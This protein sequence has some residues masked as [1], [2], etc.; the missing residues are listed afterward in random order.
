MKKIVITGPEST[1]KSILTKTIASHCKVAYVKEMARFYLE[2]LNRPYTRDD[3]S[4]I[5][6]MQLE[7]EQ[8]IQRSGGELLICDTDLR[9]IK[10]WSNY[11]YGSTDP[12]ILEEIEK[13]KV[14]L[15]LLSY[16]DIPWEEDPLRENPNDR[17]E[18][19]N[20]YLQELRQNEQIFEIVSGQFGKREKCAIDILTKYQLIWENS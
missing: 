2:M 6:K 16:P 18:L 1:G 12:Y 14:D 10:I 8:R 11:K 7:E 9:T 13:S 17:E 19:F 3:L 20:I 15:Y 4:E 5:A